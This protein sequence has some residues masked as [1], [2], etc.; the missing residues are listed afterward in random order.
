MHN[1]A[2]WKG[3]K[4]KKESKTGDL[5]IPFIFDECP[6]LPG[7]KAQILYHW[8]PQDDQVFCGEV[9]LIVSQVIKFW[10][11]FPICSPNH[12]IEAWQRNWKSC[13]IFVIELI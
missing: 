4:K 7:S 8:I 12:A 5:I 13:S 1:W 3:E 2:L 11:S 9:K 6:T 10:L